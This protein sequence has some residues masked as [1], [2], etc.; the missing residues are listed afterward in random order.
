LL[1]KRAILGAVIGLAIILFFVLGVKNP[2]PEWGQYWIAR[3]IIV[4]PLVVALAGASTSFLESL[5]QEGRLKQIIVY[6]LT[7]II[8][9]F[10][11][12]F[13]IIAGLAGTLWD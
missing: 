12:W 1:F 13:G 3:P 10:G 4:T 9:V 6:I 11:L 5:R 8:Y 7:G 2:K